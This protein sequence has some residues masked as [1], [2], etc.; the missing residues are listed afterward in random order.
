MQNELVQNLDASTT[1][2]ETSSRQHALVALA[3]WLK[4][5]AAGV[6]GVQSEAAESEVRAA[7]YRLLPKAEFIPP[8][9]CEDALA[10]MTRNQLDSPCALRAQEERLSQLV[11]D[12]ASD[13]FRTP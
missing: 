6:L 13:F 8:Q 9:D 12:F 10:V 1:V 2:N 3:P 11:E 5:W 7:F 4:A